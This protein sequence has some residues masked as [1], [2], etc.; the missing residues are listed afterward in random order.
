MQLTIF[1]VSCFTLTPCCDAVTRSNKTIGVQ[2]QMIQCI[3]WI[4]VLSKDTPSF[5][6][7]SRL[8]KMKDAMRLKQHAVWA[9]TNMVNVNEMDYEL[10][11]EWDGNEWQ[12]EWV[13]LWYMKWIDEIWY[14]KW[15]RWKWPGKYVTLRNDKNELRKN[16]KLIKWIKKEKKKLSKFLSLLFHRIPKTGNPGISRSF[17]LL[18]ILTV[19]VSLSK[20]LFFRER[21]RERERSH[22]F[23]DF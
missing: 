20:F 11:N 14:M 16:F 3:F 12:N 2:L 21:E 10:K 18:Q 6:I 5:R 8:K 19:V 13:W 1:D 15:M 4:K 23:C 17:L 7:R 22:V 9:K